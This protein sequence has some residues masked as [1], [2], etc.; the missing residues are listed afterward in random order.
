[1]RVMGLRPAPPSSPR[2][3]FSS[4]WASARFLLLLRPAA[5]SPA[6]CRR[7]CASAKRLRAPGATS[8]TLSPPD[9]GRRAQQPP[10]APSPAPGPGFWCP[11]F[12]PPQLLVSHYLQ[13]I[14]DSAPGI[15]VLLLVSLLLLKV[16]FFF[17]SPWSHHLPLL[18][19]PLWS[20]LPQPLTCE[21][22]L[23]SPARVPWLAPAPCIPP[24]GPGTS[25]RPDSPTLLGPFSPPEHN[26]S[27][28][29]TAPFVKQLF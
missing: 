29:P 1:M 6:S 7:H 17:R 10:P 28:P 15:P 8:H 13:E 9:D 21:S 11:P 22:K 20:S 26:P 23:S 24:A 16:L 12:F 27:L 5:S 4:S 25:H 2:G 18:P 3:G 14:P 19:S